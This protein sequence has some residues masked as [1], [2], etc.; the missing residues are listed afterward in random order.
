[1]PVPRLVGIQC[2]NL[3]KK[4]S[5][6]SNKKR[7]I[8][9]LVNETG[10]SKLPAI[11]PNKDILSFFPP[12]DFACLIRG[13]R[14]ISFSVARKKTASFQNGPFS[15][16]S[17]K[18]EGSGGNS[19]FQW[20]EEKGGGK[21]RNFS[22]LS[23]SQK[24]SICHQRE[25]LLKADFGHMWRSSS[26]ERSQLT[27]SDRNSTNSYKSWRTR[28]IFMSNPLKPHSFSFLWETRKNCVT[29]SSFGALLRK[30]D[31][32]LFFF[33]SCKH[34]YILWAGLVCCFLLLK[35][36]QQLSN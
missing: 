33:L 8:G 32:F 15:C 24:D 36:V 4:G 3:D 1:M 35:S 34:D 22:S 9:S 10:F 18:G 5:S 26:S 14:V 19:F 17:A 13:P 7:K 12:T 6:L 25:L 21:W 27:K 30:K 31:P 23:F 28:L 20:V 2:R 29:K 11:S 16:L